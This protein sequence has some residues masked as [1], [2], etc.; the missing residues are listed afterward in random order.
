MYPNAYH[1][2]PE[3]RDSMNRLYADEL[4]GGGFG[5]IVTRFGRTDEHKSIF[6]LLDEVSEATSIPLVTAEHGEFD[7]RLWANVQC[8]MHACKFAIAVFEDAEDRGYNPNVALEVGYLKAIEKPTLLMKSSSLDV[9]SADLLERLYI[10]YDPSGDG[11]AT[12]KHI[13]DWITRRTKSVEAILHSKVS[14]ASLTDL[15]NELYPS[16]KTSA[17]GDLDHITR[18]MAGLRKYGYHTLADVLNLL[19][20]TENARSF[21]LRD[22]L[23]HFAVCSISHSLALVHAEYRELDVWKP[24]TIQRIAEAAELF[25]DDWR[26]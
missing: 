21:I 9:M 6:K 11:E 2:P 17:P 14:Q 8:Y 10:P 5:F 12:K 15:L 16:I 18:H 25:E 3:L 13:V 19:E 20:S 26:E 22:T 4:I 7:G 1:C 23:P 24:N